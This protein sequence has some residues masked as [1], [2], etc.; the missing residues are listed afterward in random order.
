MHLALGVT[1]CVTN[2]SF[3]DVDTLAP[4]FQIIGCCIGPSHA[5]VHMVQM[6]C[7]V[8]VLGMLAGDDDII[9]ADLH[10]ASSFSPMRYA[11]CPMRSTSSRVVAR[12][13]VGFD[14]VDIQALNRRG[15]LLTNTPLA[16]RHSVATIALALILALSLR[17]PLKS[18][19]AKEGRWS[20]R[21]DFPGV[22]GPPGRTL[23][24]V[25]LGGIGRELIRLIQ[26]FAMRVIGADPFVTHDQLSSVSVELLPLEEVL[27][28]SDFVVIAC[29]LNGSTRHL[30]NA[31]RI[32]HRVDETDRFL[33]QRRPRAD[34]RGSRVDCGVEVRRA[35]GRGPRCVRARAPRSPSS[36]WKA[37]SRRLIPYAGR[38]S[39]LPGSPAPPSRASSTRS[40]DASP[41]ISSIERRQPSA[42]GT[43]ADEFFPWV[44][45]LGDRAL[46]P[47]RRSQRALSRRPGLAVLSAGRC[48]TKYPRCLSPW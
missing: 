45:R 42:G 1:S 29:L 24:V 28:R 46:S 43:M 14:A 33:R 23:G 44:E 5:H 36:R 6:R 41:N 26:P 18:R 21:G 20:E 7:D 2:G 40:R 15:I 32:A 19:L 35:G 37:S 4:G 12:N 25:G 10:G 39:S 11:S 38:T 30:I 17:V 34:N 22:G 27:A 9:H 3:R 47:S 8:N 31:S 13:G 16:V 48:Q